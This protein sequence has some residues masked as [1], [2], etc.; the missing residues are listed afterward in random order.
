[1]PSVVEFLGELCSTSPDWATLALLAARDL[2]LQRPPSRTPVLRFVLGVASTADADARGK[3]VRLLANRLFTESSLSAAIQLEATQQLNSLVASTADAAAAT[4][5]AAAE[6][7]AGQ[8]EQVAAGDDAAAAS[9]PADAE[10]QPEPAEHV[11]TQRCALYCALCTKKHSLLRHLFEM[12]ART[13]G[14]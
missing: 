10:R 3:A 6:D 12:Y 13:S 4:A 8:A 11:A 5:A 7:T 2:V 1:M 14:A 9:S